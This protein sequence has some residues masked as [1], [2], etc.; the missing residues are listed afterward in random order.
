MELAEEVERAGLIEDHL[1]RLPAIDLL[2]E[3]SLRSGTAAGHRVLLRVVVLE[4]DS[5][6]GLHL[7]ACRAHREVPIRHGGADVRR[8]SLGRGSRTSATSAGDGKSGDRE[9]GET[10][11]AQHGSL[12]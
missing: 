12:L 4:S 11:D 9:R 6:A 10:S 1:S 8:R 2:V 3:R 5:V 7:D